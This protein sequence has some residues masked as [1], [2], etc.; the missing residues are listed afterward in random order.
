MLAFN[1]VKFDRLPYRPKKFACLFRKVRRHVKDFL[2]DKWQLYTVLIVVDAGKI[3]ETLRCENDDR[4]PSL[5]EE[6]LSTWATSWETK[7]YDGRTQKGIRSTLILAQNYGM[8]PD[9]DYAVRADACRARFI[10]EKD[11]LH[12]RWPKVPKLQWDTRDETEKRIT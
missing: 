11:K 1:V 5:Y 7:Y 2:S 8:G 4:L 6:F 9:A 12:R 3:I 10:R